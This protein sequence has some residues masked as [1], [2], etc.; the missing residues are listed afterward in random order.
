M[1]QLLYDIITNI[2]HK[3]INKMDHA[4]TDWIF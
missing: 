4:D 2:R 1:L 3:A